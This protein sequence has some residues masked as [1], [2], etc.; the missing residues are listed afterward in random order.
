MS[1]N[2]TKAELA[3]EIEALKE[4]VR[5]TT[6]AG[7]TVSQQHLDAK[8]EAQQAKMWLQSALDDNETL[9]IELAKIPRWV[10]RLCGVDLND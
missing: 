3:A 9:L 7:E 6:L 10:Q 8:A 1:T 2:K 5:L 4:E